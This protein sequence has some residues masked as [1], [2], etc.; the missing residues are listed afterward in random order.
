M[1]NTNS[2]PLEN[3]SLPLLAYSPQQAAAVLGISRDSIYNLLRRGLLKS[4]SALRHKVIPH[5]EIERFLKSTL[6]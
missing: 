5:T 6:N 4:S 1:A 2:A 3:N